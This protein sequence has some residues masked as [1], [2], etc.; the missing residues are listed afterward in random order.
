MTIFTSRHSEYS[1]ALEKALQGIPLSGEMRITLEKQ[2]ENRFIETPFYIIP[3]EIYD[4]HLYGHF[5]VGGDLV[6]APIG[7]LRKRESLRGEYLE[8]DTKGNFV[9]MTEQNKNTLYLPLKATDLELKDGAST[10]SPFGVEGA[11]GVYPLVITSETEYGIKTIQLLRDRLGNILQ[12]NGRPDKSLENQIQNF[13]KGLQSR[14]KYLPARRTP[15]ERKNHPG[16]VSRQE[17]PEIKDEE[18]ID[19]EEPK[20]IVAYLDQYVVGQE[21]A[22]KILAVAFSNY[23]TK[24]RTQDEDLQK[25]NVL[26]IGP[27]GV[28]KTYMVSLLAKKASLPMVESK[29]TGKVSSGYKNE[30][31]S[32]VLEQ[33]QAMTKEDAP[34]GVIFLDEIDKIAYDGS[35]SFFGQR[36]QDELIGWLEEATYTPDT[37]QGENKKGS[38]NTKNILFITAGAFQSI[39]SGTSLEAIIERRL[40][41][42]QKR[43]G[44]TMQEASGENGGEKNS[45]SRVRPEDLITYGLKPELIGRLSSVGVLHPLTT[46]DKIR[47]LTSTKKSAI[48]K[49]AK[50]LSHKGY[51]LEINPA[52][53]RTIADRCPEETGARALNAVCNDLFTEILFDPQRFA[54]E[55]GVITISPEMA[56]GLTNLYVS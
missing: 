53:L 28:G 35:N 38:I 46:D 13:L 54:D 48:T 55:Q 1:S 51:H 25:G 7:F 23:M 42:N 15:E 19:W 49:Y 52:V 9:L 22:K 27:S 29:L 12:H 17:L 56:K 26:L 6:E 40:G 41:K 45:I 32:T 37:R 34:Y 16:T 14:R 47:I 39:E 21:N 10:I 11:Q 3:V 50:L 43:V 33:M 2:G 30:N 20:S 44:F 24:V 31:L 8:M 4:H 18:E 5:V 36:L